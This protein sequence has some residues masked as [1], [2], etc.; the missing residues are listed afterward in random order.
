VVYN[1]NLNTTAAGTTSA[2]ALSAEIIVVYNDG[3]TN[4]GVDRQLKIYPKI[5]DCACCVVKVSATV[6]KEFLCHNLGADT[7][8]DPHVPALGIHGAQ[9]QW[10]KRGPNTTGDSRVDWQ[11]AA[12][13][14]ALGFA[15]APTATNAN[16]GFVSGWSPFV[17]VNFSWRTAGGVK[18]ANDP[19]PAGYRVPT[20]AEW[21]GVNANNTVSRTGTWTNSSTNYTTALHFGPNASTKLLTLPAAGNRYVSG[22]EPGLLQNRGVGGLYWSSTENGNNVESHYMLFNSTTF[23]TSFTSREFGK[24]IRC[25]A[26]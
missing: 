4:N 9:I 3:A 1:N 21:T 2:N 19:C 12:N 10:G 5:K 15:A 16:A 11:T 20:I 17:T 26:E 14:G 8:L 23:S 25:I 18:T 7:S 24:S 22:A 6:S 13:N